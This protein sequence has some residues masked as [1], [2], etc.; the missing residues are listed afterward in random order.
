[1]LTLNNIPNSML[2]EILSFTP[3]E[4][5]KSDFFFRFFS[6]NKHFNIILH[7]EKQCWHNR[8]I[9]LDLQKPFFKYININVP[10]AESWLKFFVQNYKFIN[11]IK[12]SL[13]VSSFTFLDNFR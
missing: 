10:R 8:E 6:V 13:I 3:T 12:F 9:Y 5:Y 4:L 2:A 7:T 1:M 11:S